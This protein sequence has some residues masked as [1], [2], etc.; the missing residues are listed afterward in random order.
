MCATCDGHST[1]WRPANNEDVFDAGSAAAAG[2]WITKRS[3]S[4][5]GLQL[6]NLASAA[7][8]ATGAMF[9]DAAEQ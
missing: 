2:S 1:A 4:P 8:A 7:T 6:R 9:F 3:L 5:G